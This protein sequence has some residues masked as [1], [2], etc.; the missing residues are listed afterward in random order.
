MIGNSPT[1]KAGR[2][3]EAAC[4]ELATLDLFIPRG[5]EDLINSGV[6]NENKL[7][8]YNQ[9]RLARKRELRSIINA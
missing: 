5:L 4:A 6:F 3:A 7:S 8:A 1:Q 9:A 2:Q